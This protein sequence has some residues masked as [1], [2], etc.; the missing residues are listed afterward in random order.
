MADTRAFL[1]A[2]EGDPRIRADRIGACGY[3]MGGRMTLFAAAALADRVV[4]AAAIHPGGLV[5]PAANS[6]HLG[7]PRIRG[8][9]Y[10]AIADQDGSATPEQMTRLHAAPEA[11]G[12]PHE[13]ERYP[14]ALHGFAMP[15]FPVYDRDAA[16][17]QWDRVLALFGRT[18]AAA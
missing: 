3:C 12:V 8:E 16:E 5:T 4:A 11:A 14:G 10:F 1:A 13:I 2:V 17:R 6:P 18:L 9:L 15:D 7:A